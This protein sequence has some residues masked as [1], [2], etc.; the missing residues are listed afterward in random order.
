LTLTTSLRIIESSGDAPLDVEAFECL[1]DA[2]VRV[3]ARPLF[4]ISLHQLALDSL[5]VLPPE[6]EVFYV[7]EVWGDEQEEGAVSGDSEGAPVD[8]ARG[9]ADR[10]DADLYASAT[11]SRLTVPFSRL[12]FPPGSGSRWAPA[13]SCST[14]VVVGVSVRTGEAAGCPDAGTRPGCRQ[15]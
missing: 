11:A 9:I 12:L 15:I 2:V 4:A 5:A 13:G 3:G 8:H 7:E 6:S 10:S 14:A 1:L